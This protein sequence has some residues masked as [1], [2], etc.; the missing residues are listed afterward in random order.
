[1]LYA[2]CREREKTLANDG[3]AGRN[4]AAIPLDL[5]ISKFSFVDARPFS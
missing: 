4:L 1:M 2:Y 3:K 5:T